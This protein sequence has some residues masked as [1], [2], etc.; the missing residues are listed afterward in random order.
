MLRTVSKQRGGQDDNDLSGILQIPR[1][2]A[3]RLQDTK[4]H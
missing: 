1:E 2:D 3:K 4:D